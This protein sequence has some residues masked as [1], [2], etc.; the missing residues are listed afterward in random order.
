MFLF[1]RIVELTSSDFLQ[2]TALELFLQIV[3]NNSELYSEFLKADGI[4][5]IGSVIR[6]KKCCKGLHLLKSIIDIACDGPVLIYKSTEDQFSIVPNTMACIVHPDL[7]ISIIIRYWDWYDKDSTDCHIL[8]IIFSLLLSLVREKHPHH[9]INIH[10]LYKSGITQALLNFCKIYLVGASRSVFIS[11]LAADN[12][13]ALVRVFGGAP[14]APSLLDEIIKLLILMHRP[15]ESFVTHDRSKFYFLLSPTIPVKSNR[16]TI[17]IVTPLLNQLHRPRERKLTMPSMRR[18]THSRLRRS[19]SFDV[20][21][22]QSED[23]WFEII[24]PEPVNSSENEVQADSSKF[25]HIGVTSTYG[26]YELDNSPVIIEVNNKYLK[27]PKKI[28]KQRQFKN[29]RNQKHFYSNERRKNCRGLRRISLSD[30]DTSSLL[31]SPDRSE[32]D[33]FKA[34][35]NPGFIKIQERFFILLHD[36]ILILSDHS[37]QEVLNHYVTLEI[38]IVLSNHRDV[39]V[40]TAIIKL[41]T[42][43]CDRLPAQV[44]V[45]HTKQYYWYH[46]GNQIALNAADFSLFKVCAEWTTGLDLSNIEISD[47]KEMTVIQKYGLNVLMAILPQTV[48][49][50]NLT[51]IAFEFF[52]KLYTTAVN[53]TTYAIE[54][55]LIYVTIKTFAK[56]LYT[57]PI[58][59]DAVNAIEQFMK[60]IT[61]KSFNSLGSMAVDF[62]NL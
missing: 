7:L 49:I 24:H 19:M 9:I 32:H 14:P 13:V 40:R 52:N 21:T 42:V 23:N 48:G 31:D 46:L 43:M 36:F 12:L 25:F 35:N 26:S 50:E 22:A 27:S 62:I 29:I 4:A 33:L 16:M 8:D 15:S 56:V 51:K 30:S 45:Q 61:F 60:T 39:T 37:V 5:M 28:F 2:S 53:I 59:V 47:V 55:G 11:T 57:T 1:A 34:Y 18:S 38:L 20:N 54:N 58:D 6:T 44:I 10:R 17:P 3:Y 41:L